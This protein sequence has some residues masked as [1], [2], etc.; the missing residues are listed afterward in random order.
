[1]RKCLTLTL[2]VLALA[3]PAT[4]PARLGSLDA[5]KLVSS[6]QTGSLGVTASCNGTTRPGS[7]GS[8]SLAN[9]GSPGSTSAALALTVTTF[10]N[11]N[12][13]IWQENMQ[14]LKVLPGKPKKVSGIGSVAYESGGNGSSLAAV[15][16][17]SDF[18]LNGSK[19][20]VVH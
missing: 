12:N 8:I 5:C 11:T 19:Q 14:L 2:A 9:W 17:G 7:A 1:M 18:V 3:V 13:P 4:S 16:D 15:K 10:T 6:K 20:F